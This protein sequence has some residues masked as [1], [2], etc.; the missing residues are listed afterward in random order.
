[1][2]V[3]S[4]DKRTKILDT[5]AS[6]IAEEGVNASPMSQIA[7]KSG[8]AIGTIYHYFKSKEEIVNQ[9][10]IDIKLNFKTIIESSKAKNLVYKEEFVDVWTGFYNYFIHNPTRFKFLQQIDHSPIITT[11]TKEK[12]EQYLLPVFEFYQFGIDNDIL[13][14][15][16]LMLIGH[17]TYD[18]IM[19]MVRLKI[20]GHNVTDTILQQAVNY[21]WRGIA[22]NEKI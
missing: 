4:M 3:R 19:T 21:S 14:D 18:N 11:A 5:T 13:I 6:L 8:V 16:D 17:L 10:Y 1:M 20:A 22:K 2:N 12:G 7:K 15:M 9:I